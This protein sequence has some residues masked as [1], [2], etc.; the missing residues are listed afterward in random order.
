MRI[1][2]LDGIQQNAALPEHLSALSL[3]PVS[4]IFCPG[5]STKSLQV[6]ILPVNYLVS[7]FCGRTLLSPERNANEM[8]SLQRWDGRCDELR[9]TAKS[10]FWNN[11]PINSL[12]SRFCEPKVRPNLHNS[13]KINL[14]CD[15]LEKW[16]EIHHH[17]LFHQVSLA[18][19]HSVHMDLY[20]QLDR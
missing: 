3:I 11:L 17:L 20:V 8:N 12:F 13:H 18:H 10:L 14:L 9:A 19:E 4:R 5:L 16:S 15:R 1:R 2:S 7:R 6:K